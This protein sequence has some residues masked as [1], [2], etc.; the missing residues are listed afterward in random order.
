MSNITVNRVSTTFSDAELKGIEA[1]HIDHAKV[2][3]PKMATM[4][5][6]QA[7]RANSID[8]ANLVFVKDTIKAND[9][10]GVAMMPP[11]IAALAPELEKDD[12]FFDQLDAEEKWLLGRLEKIRE[13][14]KVVADEAY[15]VALVFYNL[16]QSLAAAGISGAQ[17]K[18][19]QLKSRFNNGGGRPD[20]KP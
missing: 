5:D 20:A 6:E 10:E 12:T 15:S 18:Y 19:E 2:I 3:D 4:T 11:A 16:Y 1:T 14:K 9:A 17:A 8:V 7:A 13:T